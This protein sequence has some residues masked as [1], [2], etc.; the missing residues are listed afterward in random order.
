MLYILKEKP[1][2]SK[3]FH[4]WKRCFGIKYSG[5]GCLAISREFQLLYKLEGW[6]MSEKNEKLEKYPKN[7]LYEVVD[8]IGVPHPYMITGKHV[9][10]AS[11]HFFGRLGEE[12]IR[13]AEKK[14]ITCGMR[15][16][17]LSYDEHKQ[18]L[19]VRVKCGGELKDAPGLKEYLME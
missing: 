4:S 2:P 19:V 1:F 5:R 6:K 15:H 17:N 18:A 7:E 12:A 13:S 8:T 9:G 3:G 16:C 10:E 11:D 14:G